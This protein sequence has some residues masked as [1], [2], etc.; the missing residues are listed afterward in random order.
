MLCKTPSKMTANPQRNSKYEQL[1]YVVPECQVSQYL[2]RGSY[3]TI[4]GGEYHHQQVAIKLVQ[5]PDRDA[6][7]GF[8]NEVRAQMRIHDLIKDDLCVP[9]V[10]LVALRRHPRNRLFYGVVVMDKIK[11][12]MRDYMERTGACESVAIKMKYVLEVLRKHGVA[13]GDLHVGNV[14]MTQDGKLCLIDFDYTVTSLSEELSAD[15]RSYLR[16]V[17]AASVWRI[18]LVHGPVY[19]SLNRALHH[20][21]FPGS[22]TFHAVFGTDK[23]EH[24]L[25]I[26]EADDKIFSAGLG[27]MR[28]AQMLEQADDSSYNV[29]AMLRAACKKS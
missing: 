6:Y 15:H 25:S 17:D 13:H 4:L 11:M 14:G 9:K 28:R 20:V 22:D 18:S 29:D 12:T 27:V 26:V 19:A 16:D 8:C 10:H 21:G 2:G 5:V 3:A 24:N 23:P 1:A 7:I